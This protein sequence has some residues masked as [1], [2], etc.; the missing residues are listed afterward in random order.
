MCAYPLTSK[1]M[2]VVFPGHIS[3]LTRDNKLKINFACFY[4]T[5]LGRRGNA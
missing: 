3:L 2:T 5:G 1:C 4:L